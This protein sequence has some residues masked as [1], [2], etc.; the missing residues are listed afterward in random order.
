[1][2]MRRPPH[3]LIS[4]IAGILA[5]VAIDVP[6]ARA[7]SPREFDVASI[8]PNQSGGNNSTTNTSHGRFAA[9]NV[10]LRRLIQSAFDVNDFQ[11]VGGPAWIGTEKYDVEAKADVSAV[12]GHVD[13]GPM[14]QALL[15]DRFKLKA[16]RETKE[17]PVYSLVVAKNGPK[18]T[19]HSGTDGASTNTSHGSGKA[20]LVAMQV[21][22]AGL[23]DRLGR[24]LGAAVVDNTGLK[25][26]YDVKLEWA[27]NQTADSALPSLFIAL[28]EQLGLRLESTKGPV[29]VVVIDSAEK[30]S[31]N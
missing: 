28:Q 8:K 14:L 20:T 24:D 5:V 15:A 19:V 4:A 31:E 13:Y 30:A 3:V 2:M 23:A 9:T 6:L 25:G 16:H 18:L 17:L 27:P 12:T 29:E 26:E 7:Q 1:M 10:S 21:S 22:M 11:I